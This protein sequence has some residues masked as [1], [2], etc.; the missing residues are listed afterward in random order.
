MERT[1]TFAGNLKRYRTKLGLTQK[2]L[3]EK[4]GYTEK[5]VSK[6]ESGNALPTMEIALKL[7][8]LFSISLDALMFEDMTCHYFLGIDG[9]GTKTAF[10]LIDQ[11]GMLVNQITKGPS[12]P[13]DIGIE[14]AISVLRDGIHEV[15]RGIPC[16][17]V[18]LFAGLAGFG[19]AGDNTKILHRFLEKF[20]FFAFDS[21]SDIENIAALSD[22][23]KCILVIMGT[24]FVAYALQGSDKKRV[25][26][27][28]Q[29]FDEGGCGYTLGKDAITAVLAAEDGSGAPTLLTN[30][31]AERLGEPASAHLARF[32]QGGKRYIADFANLVF[33]AAEAKD[34]I[35]QGILETNAVYVAEK[36]TAAGKHL[37]ENHIPVI[38]AGGISSQHEMLFPMFKK[39]LADKYQLLYLEQAPVNGA[40]AKAKAIY[41]NAR[42]EGSPDVL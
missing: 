27:W 16:S 30:L 3:A 42:Q 19:M 36:I 31:F 4:I 26:G 40:I 13:Y 29:Y 14:S 23:K 28:G 11:E 33:R 10:K 32:Y 22:R 6:W 25:A 15:C 35:A 9:G 17:K 24:G 8:D 12:N 41:Q 7:T 18:T 21:G 37:S 5:S 34:A 2:Q 1:V 39:H 38:F 20:D